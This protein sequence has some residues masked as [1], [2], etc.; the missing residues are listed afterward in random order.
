MEQTIVPDTEL[1]VPENC[2][3]ATSACQNVSSCW[4][5][6]WLS[7]SRRGGK[8]QVVSGAHTVFQ[9]KFPRDCGMGRNR[10]G[11]DTAWM[12]TEPGSEGGRTE[13]CKLKPSLQNP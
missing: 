7:L 4:E 12:S 6:D 1:N 3:W 2:V 8:S 9:M 10:A 5:E 13:S 11:G